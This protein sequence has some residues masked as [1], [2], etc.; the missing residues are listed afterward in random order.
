M[1]CSPPISQVRIEGLK[2]TK[3]THRGCTACQGEK[4]RNHLCP[5]S[6]TRLLLPSAIILTNSNVKAPLGRLCGYQ[7][8]R[9]W[10][11]REGVLVSIGGAEVPRRRLLLEGITWG[12][13]PGGEVWAAAAL[14]TASGLL[15]RGRGS[16]ACAHPSTFSVRNTSTGQTGRCTEGNEWPRCLRDLAL[17]PP[18]E[19]RARTWS[20]GRVKWLIEAAELR[21]ELTSPGPW[22]PSEKVLLLF[23]LSKSQRHLFPLSHE[24]T[25]D[26]HIFI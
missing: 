26:S 3:L 7:G 11:V 24:S 23:A 22:F 12:F 25:I 10:D 20:L 21:F 18:C 19:S 9:W 6:K 13:R 2:R 4:I 8:Y 17:L 5:T 16:L 15:L 1:Y 14:I